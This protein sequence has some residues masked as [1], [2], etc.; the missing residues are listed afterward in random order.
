MTKATDRRLPLTRKVREGLRHM[1]G[2]LSAGS[3][4]DV[5]ELGEETSA[6]LDA[7]AR[8]IHSL[9]DDDQAAQS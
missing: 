8:W 3:M 6:E 2:A 5:Q 9:P 1:A 4:Q 7:A